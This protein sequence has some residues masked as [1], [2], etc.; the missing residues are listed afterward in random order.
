MDWVIQYETIKLDQPE[1]LIGRGMFGEV[2]RGYWYQPIALKILNMDHIE[3][4][5]QL[6]AFK[7]DV[8]TFNTTVMSKSCC[9]VW[10]AGAVVFCGCC[11]YRPSR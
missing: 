9:C 5:K 3:T 1:S 2:H 7:Q 10:F 8:S 6:E 11:L 4:E